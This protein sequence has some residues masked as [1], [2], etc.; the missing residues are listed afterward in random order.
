[1]PFAKIIDESTTISS[2]TKDDKGKSRYWNEVFVFG[3]YRLLIVSQWY[4]KDKESFD[5]WFNGLAN[6]ETDTEMEMHTPPLEDIQ[7]GHI[8]AKSTPTYL[9]IFG[10]RHLVNTWH[11]LYFKACQILTNNCPYVIALLD[12]DKDLN[13]DNQTNFSYIQHEIKHN[14]KR[15]PNGLWMEMEKGSNEI[16]SICYQ[17]FEKCGFPSDELQIETLED[18]A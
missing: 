18:L 17:L 5:N 8:I 14:P 7:Q 13:F 15:L 6:V 10:K 9:G 11:E 12:G 3:E 1:M 16:V 2:Q 4:T